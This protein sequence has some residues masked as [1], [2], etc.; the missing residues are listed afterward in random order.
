MK[1]LAEPIEAAVWFKSKVKPR[2]FKFRYRDREG[3]VRKINVENSIIADEIKT[4][5]IWAFVH[6]FQ[7][8][9]DGIVKVY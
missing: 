7:S 8:E 5:E 6:R 3:L 4:A 9:I 1:I 2:T